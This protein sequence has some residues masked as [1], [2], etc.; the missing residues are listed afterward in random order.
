M[1]ELYAMEK[2]EETDLSR[3]LISLEENLENIYKLYIL[4]LDLLVQIKK[5][6]A[7]LI[8]KRKQKYFKTE[9]DIRPNT[10]LVENRL[11]AKLEN[12]LHLQDLKEK[13]KLQPIWENEVELVRYLLE[14]IKASEF[15]KNYIE[16]EKNDFQSDKEFV[17]NI[18]KNII[19]PDEK[20]HQFLEDWEINWSDDVAIANT[21]V[22]KTLDQ[23]EEKTN[24]RFSVPPLYKDNT[25]RQF[26]RDLLLR[27]WQN[28]E[29]L[30]ELIKSKTINWDFDRISNVDKI[31]MAM[32]IA[33]FLYFPE[34]PETAT[35][36]EY[37]EIAKEFSTPKSNVFVNGILDKLYK[38]LDQNNKI[39]KTYKS[40]KK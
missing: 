19:A 40:I 6:E 3:S 24:P 12:N 30:Y 36:N 28:K 38:E 34:I 1:Q 32:A 9:E 20:L 27:T 21:L 17:L 37:V 7:K 26:G 33:E 25:D 8:Q 31:L 11:I 4:L 13:Y 14:K 18:Y 35:I 10:R 29:Y 5:Y 39:Q 22:M 16:E 2:K 23:I 15:Y